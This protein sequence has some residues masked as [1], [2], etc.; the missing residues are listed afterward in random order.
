MKCNRCGTE[1][2]ENAVVCGC[3]GYP[4]EN[5]ER[6]PQ[7]PMKWYKFLVSFLLPISIFMNIIDGFDMIT[8]PDVTSMDISGL[9]EVST[10][11][12]EKVNIFSGVCMLIIALFMIYAL[13]TLKRFGKDSLNCVR[14]IYISNALVNVANAY[15]MYKILGEQALSA[16][17]ILVFASIVTAIFMCVVNTIYFNNR[18]DIFIN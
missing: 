12:L 18:K 3:C 2:N 8:N 5:K 14:A 15:M 6:K 16:V 10:K 11:A 9:G 13:R 1:N 17:S 4:L 7:K